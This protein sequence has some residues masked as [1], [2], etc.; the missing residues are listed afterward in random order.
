MNI[1]KQNDSTNHGRVRGLRSMLKKSSS[2][3]EKRLRESTNK[4][5]TSNNCQND[6][7]SFNITP[8]E[9]DLLESIEVTNT[10][11][12]SDSEDEKPF[13]ALAITKIEKED[14]TN[15]TINT[16]SNQM[17][18]LTTVSSS[19]NGISNRL[20]QKIKQVKKLEQEIKDKNK[21]IEKQKER[22]QK[23]TEENRKLNVIIII[24][25]I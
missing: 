12:E 1:Q 9:D 8:D 3:D 2:V 10:K 7:V 15:N 11:R 6:E 13:G 20:L 21:L 19:N 18:N 16:T 25:L 23:L 14:S 4:T 5:N 17:M 24:L 22:I